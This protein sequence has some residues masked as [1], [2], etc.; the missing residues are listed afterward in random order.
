M[1]RSLKTV[2]I[3]NDFQLRHHVAEVNIDVQEI[4][5]MHDLAAFAHC[6]LGNNNAESIG[7]IPAGSIN[8]VAGT[9]ARHDESIG[10]DVGQR[11]VKIGPFEG[12]CI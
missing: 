3:L 6:L 4:Y 2:E 12:R 1:E 8:T 11:F 5:F 10:P 7:G 9:D